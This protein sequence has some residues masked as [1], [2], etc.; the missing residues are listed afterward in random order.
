[1]L[2]MINDYIL[3]TIY[4]FVS[5]FYLQIY[6]LGAWG[7]KQQTLEFPHKVLYFFFIL[8]LRTMVFIR[9][10]DLSLPSIDLMTGCILGEK[11]I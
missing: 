7:K 6:H 2:F 8:Y 10:R 4:S 1:M 9:F 5:I 3:I 11:C